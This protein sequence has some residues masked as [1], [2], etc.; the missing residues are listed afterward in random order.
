M[1]LGL[2]CAACA[3][4]VRAASGSPD[5]VSWRA[6]SRDSLPA[7]AEL[8]VR[9]VNTIAVNDFMLSPPAIAGLSRSQFT[10]HGR[11]GWILQERTTQH[12]W[13]LRKFRENLRVPSR[14]RIAS[15]LPLRPYSPKRQRGDSLAREPSPALTLGAIR[16]W[17]R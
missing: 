5:L 11:L 14:F 13:V 16:D 6:R 9:H 2:D 4:S 12:N 8:N 1:S 17:L 3:S 10:S 15:G 7:R